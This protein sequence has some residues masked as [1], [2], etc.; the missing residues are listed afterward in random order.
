MRTGQ[1]TRTKSLVAGFQSLLTT[2]DRWTQLTN[3]GVHY[4][5]HI[6]CPAAGQDPPLLFSSMPF[7]FNDWNFNKL[8]ALL[9]NKSRGFPTPCRS[10]I[11]RVPSGLFWFSVPWDSL[12][13]RGC[14]DVQP[15]APATT[16][17]IQAL[18]YYPSFFLHARKK[19]SYTGTKILASSFSTRASSKTCAF[20]GPDAR[21][22]SEYTEARSPP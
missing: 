7:N 14:G 22:R 17:K 2:L 8:G 6:Q 11:V 1:E 4:Q 16:E 3:L 21:S 5:Q 20:R 12:R 15:Y 13:N 9:L 19:F 10:K 18:V